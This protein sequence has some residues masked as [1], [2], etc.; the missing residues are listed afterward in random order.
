MLVAENINGKCALFVPEQQLQSYEEFAVV[1]TD[2][3]D[4]A[5]NLA[6]VL[7]G[8]KG[9]DDVQDLRFEP[10]FDESVTRGAV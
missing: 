7:D 4:A 1:D 2:L 3:R 8:I 6:A 10:S 5:W 9:V